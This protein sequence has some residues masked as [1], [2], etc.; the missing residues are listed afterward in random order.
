AVKLE[1]PPVDMEVYTCNT[2][3]DCEEP[4]GKTD[5][6]SSRVIVGAASWVAEEA[7][8][9][10]EYFGK[11]GMTND[12]ISALLVY[13]MENQAGGIETAEN[14]LSTEQDAWTGWVPEDVAERVIASLN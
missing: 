2:N 3:T 9:V 5:W 8:E 12:Q 10:A 7:P 4:A 13:G 6:P 1:M 11:V 14:F